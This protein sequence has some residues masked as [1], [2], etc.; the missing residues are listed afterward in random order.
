[1]SLGAKRVNSA[2]RLNGAFNVL[3]GIFLMLVSYGEL[4]YASAIYAPCV[5]PAVNSLCFTIPSNSSIFLGPLYM[6]V[7]IGIILLI[8]STKLIVFGFLA[9]VSSKNL[10]TLP[11]PVAKKKP[12]E[13]SV[14]PVPPAPSQQGTPVLSTKVERCSFCDAELAFD[15]TYC[16]KCFQRRKI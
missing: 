5:P 7:G 16:P 13:V 1:M 3:L 12:E 14:V 8:Y 11:T 2:P 4:L 10:A 9:I 6:L 15:A